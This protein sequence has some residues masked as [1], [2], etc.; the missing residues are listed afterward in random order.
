MAPLALVDALLAFTSV[1][2]AASFLLWR[3]AFSKRAPACHPSRVAKASAGPS[4]D[5]VL[6][7]SLAKGLA[8]AKAAQK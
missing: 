5:V 2:G 1:V 3:L 6:G 8:R 4:P 7:G